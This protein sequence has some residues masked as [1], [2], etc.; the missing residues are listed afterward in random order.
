MISKLPAIFLLLVIFLPLKIIFGEIKGF[1]WT[2]SPYTWL[3]SITI[4]ISLAW[5]INAIFPKS[6][7]YILKKS[8][9]YFNFFIQLLPRFAFLVIGISL[10]Y[11]STYAFSNRPLLIDSIVQL[12]QAEIFKSGN[13]KA[14]L[15]SHLEF[16]VTQ[17]MIFDNSGWYGQYPPGHSLLLIPGLLI[18]IPWIIPI[19]LSIF[20]AYII[21]KFTENLFG[22]YTAGISLLLLCLSPFYLF[23]GASYMNHVSSLLL[24]ALV[25]YCFER[26][27][28]TNSIFFLILLSFSAGYQLLVRPLDLVAISIV[29]IVPSIRIFLQKPIHILSALF[30]LLPPLLFGL[31]YNKK[32]TGDFF[33]PGYIKL[34]GA[35]HGLGFHESPWGH[36]HTPLTGLRNELVDLQLVQEMLFEGSLPSLYFVAIYLLIK[37]HLPIWPKRLLAIGFTF[38]L[39][40]FF[41]WHRDSFLGPRFM[42]STIV[43]WIPLTAFSIVQLFRIIGEIEVR[44]FNLFKTFYLKNFFIL[45]ILISFIFTVSINLPARF[46]TYSSSLKSLKHD[47]FKEAEN[48]Q[49][50]TGLIFIKT[51]WGVRI[52]SRLRGLGL[53]ASLVQ[54]AYTF[55]DHCYLHELLEASDTNDWE[56]KKIEEYILLKLMAPAPTKFFNYNS[57]LTLRLDPKRKIT[58]SCI[59]EMKYDFKNNERN[60]TVYEPYMPA[61]DPNFNGPFIFAKDL[62]SK[63]HI[64]T[65]EHPNLKAYIY[66][67]K[68]F[69]EYV[70]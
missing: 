2:T 7:N 65:K 33:L 32:T 52:I 15:P 50:K 12:F 49:I 8:S 61:N 5:L 38:P 64:L 66:D 16:F 45:T 24:C 67:G 20:S 3:L 13:F 31:Y 43:A 47:I 4:T 19:L 39:M 60:Y 22:K 28:K 69:R 29:L 59:N 25:L 54:K 35:S 62:R 21:F 58:P 42:Y 68:K 18:D 37:K 48:H 56:S 11:I 51:S 10:A 1:K 27:E 53:S 23:M 26:W 46:Y 30:G 40:Y 34:W 55:L 36:Q 57:D 9:H 6:T 70:Y 63:N 14:V 41:Y 17:H 44:P